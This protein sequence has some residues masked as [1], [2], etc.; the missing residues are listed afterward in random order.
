M[1]YRYVPKTMVFSQETNEI[2]VKVVP[3]FLAEHS[4]L[5]R[6]EFVWTYNIVIENKS[7]RRIKLMRRHW[8]LTD[9]QGHTE[10]VMGAGVVGQQPVLEPGQKYTYA[11]HAVLRTSTGFMRGDYD[12]VDENGSHLKVN[13]PAFSLDE[14][15]ARPILN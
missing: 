7:P 5:G 10:E 11:S 2:T 14:P 12:M 13:I 1:V 15:Y 8:S 4:E 6:K 3:T 9:A